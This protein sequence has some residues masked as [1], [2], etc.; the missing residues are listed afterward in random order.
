VASTA[1]DEVAGSLEDAITARII[2]ET[3]SI[4]RYSFAHTLIRETIYEQLSRT[5]RAQLHRMIGEAIEDAGEG[6]IADE[7]A[8]RLAY[9][10]TAAGDLDRACRYHAIAAAAAQRVYAVEPAL[11]HYTAALE[12]GA[13]LGR[14][15]D[16]DPALRRLMLQRGALRWRTEDLGGAAG[17]LETC[18]V[19]AQQSGDRVTELEILN[20]LGI[21]QGQLAWA[22]LLLGNRSEATALAAHAHELLEH[23]TAP[24]GAA[25]LFGV[26]AYTAVARVLLATGAPERGEALLLP[27]RDAASRSG[28]GRR[29]R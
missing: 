1:A 14:E 2:E 7:S 20:E 25:F 10:F 13:E 18:L 29:S 6:E 9:H 5:R 8:N 28:C 21:M 22:R 15:A 17:D 4:G 23:V 26:P 16:R 27:V 12:A 11:A 3:G 19:A 24:S